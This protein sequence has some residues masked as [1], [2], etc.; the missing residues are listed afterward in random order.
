MRLIWQPALWVEGCC[1]ASLLTAVRLGL[2]DFRHSQGRL[3]QI[4][5]SEF[6]EDYIAKRYE[7]QVGWYDKKAGW[8]RWWYSRIQWTMIVFSAVTPVLLSAR[9]ELPQTVAVFTSLG[10]AI[11][12]AGLK[13]FRF[14]ELWFNYRSTCEALRTQFYLF[15]AGLGDF[16]NPET[17]EARFVETVEAML[18]RENT[19]WLSSANSDRKREEE[20]EGRGKGPGEGD[21]GRG[22]APDH[23]DAPMLAGSGAGPGNGAGRRP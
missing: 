22:D 10:V 21:P 20:P 11:L 14:E 5:A 1:P 8:N 12:A 6:I 23:G 3:V 2:H 7:D 17:R 19:L 16:S 9:H 4:M 15:R 18:S 13:A